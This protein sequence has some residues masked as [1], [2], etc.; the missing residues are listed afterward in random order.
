M[1]HGDGL[2][3]TTNKLGYNKIS[4]LKIT[5]QRSMLLKFVRDKLRPKRVTSQWR[6]CTGTM[7]VPSEKCR[8]SGRGVRIP[9]RSQLIAHEVTNI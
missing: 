7:R 4:V 1:Y 9:R 6:V 2:L 8:G 5:T 3:E